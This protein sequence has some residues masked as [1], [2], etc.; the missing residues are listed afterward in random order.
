MENL[1]MNKKIGLGAGLAMLIACFLPLVTYEF[2][3]FKESYSMWDAAT[4]KDD[5]EGQALH[6][7]YFI[8][9]GGALFFTWTDNLKFARIAFAAVLVLFLLQYFT[10]TTLEEALEAA[11]KGEEKEANYINKEIFDN[12]GIGLWLLLGSAAAGGFFSKE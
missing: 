3:G 12:A 11:F 2:M 6:F 7:L 1:S 8:L 5:A 9:A 4:G 10:G